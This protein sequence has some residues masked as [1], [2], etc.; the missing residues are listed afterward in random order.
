MAR[1]AIRG[2]RSSSVEAF[3]EMMAA[4]RGAAGNTLEAY[5]RDLADAEA[6]LARASARAAGAER[7]LAATHQALA[8]SRGEADELKRMLA[9][10][11]AMRLEQGVR[12][13]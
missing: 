2:S 4:E 9:A 13:G 8:A 1:R 7:E 10:W 3:L 5:G 6:C 11:E 12:L